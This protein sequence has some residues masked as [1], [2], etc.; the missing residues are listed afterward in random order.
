M[1][2]D[3]EKEVNADI[4]IANMMLDPVFKTEV[5]ADTAYVGGY[6]GKIYYFCS[7]CSKKL[8]EEHPERY[9]RISL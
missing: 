8:F 2:L 6:E 9:T 7:V 4:V 3:L 1:G 5:A